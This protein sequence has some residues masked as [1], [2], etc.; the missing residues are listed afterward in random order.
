MITKF[1]IF[2]NLM[3]KSTLNQMNR[4]NQEIKKAGGDIEDKVDKTDR[5]FPNQY[6]VE[7]PFDREKQADTIDDHMKIDIPENPDH[8]KMKKSKKKNEN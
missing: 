2:E 6:W 1:K 4:I 5:N 8:K 3:R 7:N